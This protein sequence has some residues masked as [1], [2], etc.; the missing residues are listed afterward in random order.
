MSNNKRSASPTGSVAGSVRGPPATATNVARR[1]TLSNMTQGTS[2]YGGARD[3]KDVDYFYG[4]KAKLKIFLMQ[5]KLAFLADSSR[6]ETSESQVIFAAKKLR[7]AAFSWFEPVLTERVEGNLSSDNKRTFMDFKEFERQ[8]N[9]V[10][11]EANEGRAAARKLMQLRQKGSAT[12]Y[13]SLFSQLASRLDW[14]DEALASRYYEGLSDAIKDQMIPEPPSEYQDLVNLSIQIDNRLYE[15]RMEKGGRDAGPR[16][17]GGYRANTPR[18]RDYGDPMDLS[19]L[20]KRPSRVGSQLSQQERERRKR[21]NLC[22]NCGKSGHRANECRSGR[23][24]QLHM[25]IQG[26]A[27]MLEKKADTSMRPGMPEEAPGRA[28]KRFEDTWE[29]VQSPKDL[30]DLI[31]DTDQVTSHYG[32]PVEVRKE[33]ICVPSRIKAE[34]FKQ[35]PGSQEDHGPAKTQMLAMMTSG[36]PKPQIQVEEDDQDAS[37]SEEEDPD[38]IKFVVMGFSSTHLRIITPYWRT[39]ECQPHCGNPEPHRHVYFSPNTTPK[40]M[41]RTLQMQFCRDEECEAAGL[42]VHHGPFREVLPVELPPEIRARYAW[43]FQNRQGRDTTEQSL[44]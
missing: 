4:D 9:L 18:R 3:D 34:K 1:E 36:E 35:T 29:D 33:P 7:G 28:Q 17:G 23:A 19:M 15:R 31:T 40:E 22:Y 24:Q 20:S 5:C 37:S 38:P 32:E 13:Y 6:F 12:Q 14:D 8:I 30:G 21:E 39:C 43:I 27:G 11:G 2:T 41:P 42:H 25:M 26:K 16:F 10:Y 44:N